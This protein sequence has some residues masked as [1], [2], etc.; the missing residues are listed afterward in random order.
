MSEIPD[1]DKFLE[2]A[3]SQRGMNN[4]YGETKLD[5]DFV[6]APGPHRKD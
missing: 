3:F 2:N 1:I 6:D 4:L 5:P